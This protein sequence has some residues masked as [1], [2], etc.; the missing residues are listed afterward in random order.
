MPAALKFA[1]AQ[2]TPQVP[3]GMISQKWSVRGL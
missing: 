2:Q 3:P 1:G